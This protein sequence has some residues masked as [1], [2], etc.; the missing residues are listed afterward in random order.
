MTSMKEL[1]EDLGYVANAVRRTEPR[2]TPSI[3]LLWAI[4][5]LPGFAL[6]DLDA[7]WCR[8]YWLIAAPIAA[9]LSWW[10]GRKD[11]RRAK[12][13][14][15]AGYRRNLLGGVVC[16]VAFSMFG[17]IVGASNIPPVGVWQ[18]F[19]LVQGLVFT[20]A[21][22]YRMREFIPAGLLMFVGCALLFYVP[23]RLLGT[24][25][26]VILSAAMMTGWIFTRRVKQEIES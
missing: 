7:G 18:L 19:L 12:E 17:Q 3:F 4:V 16:G 21:G 10:L 23:E 24:S 15:P 9:L 6:G 13:L 26:G 11:A 22:V 20:L 8:H 14:D 2:A 25:L 5:V 1:H